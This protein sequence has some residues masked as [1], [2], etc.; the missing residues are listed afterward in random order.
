[1]SPLIILLIFLAYVCIW[2]TEII[3]D[4]TLRRKKQCVFIFDST[5]LGYLR[6]QYLEEFFFCLLASYYPRL[7]LQSD[8]N[9]VSSHLFGSV[10]W[11]GRR[12]NNQMS[13]Y[14]DRQL[15]LCWFC[16]SFC[17]CDHFIESIVSDATHSSVSETALSSR[18]QM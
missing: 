2:V 1:M 6:V 3:S 17:T 11:G 4:I 5:N 15:L 16:Q 12:C 7:I 18:T 9:L 13:V 8:K 14:Q 10:P